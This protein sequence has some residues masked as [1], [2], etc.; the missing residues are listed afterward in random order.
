MKIAVGFL[1]GV[2]ATLVVFMVVFCIRV[3]KRYPEILAYYQKARE[4]EQ[5]NA[6]HRETYSWGF[7][8][9]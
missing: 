3:E 8:D 7:D 9:A 2:L 5:K 6:S 1:L 4:Q